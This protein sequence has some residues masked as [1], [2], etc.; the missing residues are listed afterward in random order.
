MQTEATQWLSLS[1]V[2]TCAHSEEGPHVRWLVSHADRRANRQLRGARQKS[3]KLECG[4]GV[5]RERRTPQR[6]KKT[7]MGG[8]GKGCNGCGKWGGKYGGEQNKSALRGA[9]MREESK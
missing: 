8:I 4:G 7:R 2:R 9:E 1:N 6:R 3:V 5:E